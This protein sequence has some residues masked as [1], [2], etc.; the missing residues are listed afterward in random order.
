M[1][2]KSLFLLVVALLPIFGELGFA[3]STQCLE[4]LQIHLGDLV[5]HTWVHPHAIFDVVALVESKDFKGEMWIHHYRVVVWSASYRMV[6]R[7][8]GCFHHT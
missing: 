4:F 1:A 6:R 2:S 7:P 3:R 5:E 8:G